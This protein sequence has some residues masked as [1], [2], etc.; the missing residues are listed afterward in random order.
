MQE[1]AKRFKFQ[2]ENVN[3]QPYEKVVK[4]IKIFSLE[5][6]R[7]IIGNTIDIGI[8]VTIDLGEGV[9][10]FVIIGIDGDNYIGAKILLETSNETSNRIPI[11][12]NIDVIYRNLTYKSIVTIIN[13]VTY[14]LKSY[15]FKGVIGRVVNQEILDRIILWNSKYEEEAPSSIDPLSFEETVKTAKSVEDIINSFCLKDYQ[16]AELA[17]ECI[18]NNTRSIK[19]LLPILQK[20][21]FPNLTQREIK[22][23]LES[24]LNQWLE[25]YMIE[26]QDSS[27]QYFL[28]VIQKQLKR[29]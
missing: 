13:Q 15:N 25:K 3:F 23:L 7:K 26:M 10:H 8:I 19:V 9:E 29:K 28:K 1:I 18:N 2:V 16:L 4:P 21:E 24:Q 5:E 17:K 6:R 27:I 20:K 11:L 12:K 22:E 14:T